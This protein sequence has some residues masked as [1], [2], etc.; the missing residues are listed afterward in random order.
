[1]KS[2]QSL[3]KTT[4]LLFI[5]LIFVSGCAS[6]NKMT[7]KIDPSHVIAMQ[8]MRTEITGMLEDLGYQWHFI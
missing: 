1:M 7:L 5:I 3:I 4:I 8:D 2:G 6:T